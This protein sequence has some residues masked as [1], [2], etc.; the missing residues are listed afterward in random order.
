MSA[1]I[2]K[3]H[4][5]LIF[6]L[7][8]GIFLSFKTDE[9][10]F[11]KKAQIALCVDFSKSTQEISNAVRDNLWEMYT[12][13]GEKYPQTKLEIAIVG[14]SSKSFGR[15]SG[16]V[17]VLS[18]FTDDPQDFFEYINK[19]K[20]NSSLPDNNIGKALNAC[21]GELTWDESPSVKKQIYAI[22]N[23]PI[24]DTYALAKKVC[25]KAKKNK[26]LIHV[27]YV[28]H[29]KKDTSFGYWKHLTELSGGKIKTIVSRYLSEKVSGETA[30]NL[31]RI[32]EENEL[33]NSTYLPYGKLGTSKLEQMKAIDEQS[34]LFGKKVIG[35]RSIYKSSPYYQNKQLNWDLVDLANSKNINFKNLQ[36]N[37]LPDY[38]QNMSSI[39][40][41]NLIE[42][43]SMERQSYLDIIN[44][45]SYTNR[46]IKADS[47]KVPAYKLDLSS[48]IIKLFTES[49]F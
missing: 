19:K 35:N 36:T 20:L 10:R 23:G 37:L 3:L 4:K 30:S 7:I 13:F 8:S 26:I 34:K 42:Q 11:N 16:Y 31:T 33:L 5:A 24:K 44:I 17:K 12:E 43:K 25:N 47:P 6:V 27:L 46:K 28:I 40:I 15:K 38:M 1:H 45:L 2:L 29:K 32:T 14:Y 39:E 9:N 41:K 22:G 48:T 49:G 18:K 21:L